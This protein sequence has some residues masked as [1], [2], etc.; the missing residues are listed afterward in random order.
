MINNRGGFLTIGQSPRDDVISEIKPL[1]N[2]GAEII[3]Y[4]LL[5]DLSPQE[6]QALAPIKNETL[7][8]SRLMDGTQIKLGEKKI[9]ALLPN[10]VDLMKTQ[11]HVNVVGVLCTHEFSQM[12]FS[13]PTIFPFTSLQFLL[14]QVLEVESL[15][16]VVPSESQIETAQKKWGEGLTTVEAKSPY[17]GGKPWQEI[18]ESFA[19]K[20]VS[21]IVL[22]CIGY[23][24]KDRQAVQN[25]YP[26]PTLLPRTLLAYAINQLF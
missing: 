4:G 23:T 8:V 10:A 19:Q 12:K 2:P 5:D 18:A 14:E 3:Q 20:K 15:G 13:L 24:K 26:I 16:V 22:D 11:M 25:A 21:V 6:I 7:L 1:L 17:A 9:S